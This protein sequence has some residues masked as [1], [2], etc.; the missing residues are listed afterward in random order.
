MKYVL[1]VRGAAAALA[2]CNKSPTVNAK[3]AT[4]E[5]VAKKVEASGADANMVR[6]GLWQSKVTIEKFEIP[7]MPPE[8]GAKDEIGDG[9][10]PGPRIPRHA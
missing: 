3:N 6:P 4:P 5:E 9:P 1:L 10:G 7:G 8:D 2:A